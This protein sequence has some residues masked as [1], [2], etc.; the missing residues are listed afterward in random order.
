MI[1]QL[2]FTALVLTALSN[3]AVAIDVRPPASANSSA[4][5]LNS[6][7][8]MAGEAKPIA[9]AKGKVEYETLS[10]AEK[11]KLINE[12][13]AASVKKAEIKWKSMT[14]DEK[15]AKYEKRRNAFIARRNAKAQQNAAV[16]PASALAPAAGTS[17]PV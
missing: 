8:P 6:L 5:T 3:A 1:K 11:L 10:R 16:A 14:D 12:R 15:I 4:V 7:S 13:H 9:A 2:T 17:T